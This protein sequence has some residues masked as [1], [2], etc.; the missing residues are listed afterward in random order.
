M[1][2]AMQPAEL[3]ALIAD[4]LRP[5]DA[6]SRP[7]MTALRILLADISAIKLNIKMQGYDLAAELARALPVPSGLE[8]RPIE[9]ASKACTQ[10]DMESDWC[11]Y[12]LGRLHIPRVFHR[13][14]WELA[15][16]LQ[17]LWQN[18]HLEAGQ[19][20]LGFGCGTE[21][22]PSL[23]ASCGVDV[24]A[25]DLAEEQQTSLGW[26]ATGQHA[27][28][29]EVL[30]RSY[31][32]DR[33]AFDAHVSLRY[34][35]MNAIPAD[36]AG[37]DFCWS[38][39]AL[40]HLGSIRAG[41]DFIEASLGP[42]RSGGTAVHTTEFNYLDDERTVDNW[43]TVLF[44]RAHFRSL[45]ERLRAKGHHVAPLDFDV[46]AKPLDRF[47]DMPPYSND[48]T[49]NQRSIWPKTPPHLKLSVDGF[50]STCFGLVI[51]KA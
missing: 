11:A 6:L 14:L 45:A 40:E 47:I 36:L 51:R 43:A 32:V 42:L 28:S 5:T 48:W 24:V 8:A 9:L 46:G 30:Y 33:P 18:G 3:D 41:L 27:K 15:Y 29:L 31:L 13:K 4:L 1:R 50:A 23:L 37:F 49:E 10:A 20:G 19:K 34:V 21:P 39:C 7:Q 26:S 16:V 2:R 22:I 35:D 44:Q 38:I 17:A 12:W 25:T